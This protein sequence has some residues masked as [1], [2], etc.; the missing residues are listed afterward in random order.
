MTKFSGTIR[1]NV[2]PGMKARI[3]PETIEGQQYQGTEFIIASEPRE[4][5]G[6]VVVA[7]NELDGTE[8][9]EGYALSLLQITDTCIA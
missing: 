6:L 4:S 9:C 7:L 5:G 3:N 2:R 8:F 1:V